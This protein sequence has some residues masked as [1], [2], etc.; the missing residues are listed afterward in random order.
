M[1]RW[2]RAHALG[3]RP[4][5]EVLAVLLKAEENNDKNAEWAY[6]GGL[7]TTPI[8]AKSD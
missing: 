8:G 7:L 3:L 5:P 1:K 6:I 2:R 4:P